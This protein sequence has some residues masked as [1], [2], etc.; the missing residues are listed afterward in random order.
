MNASDRIDV[1]TQE[2][3]VYNYISELRA[4]G[5]LSI[6]RSRGVSGWGT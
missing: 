2:E 4:R 6:R 5:D 3:E 1:A